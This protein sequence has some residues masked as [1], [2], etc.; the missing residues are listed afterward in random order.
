MGRQD[1]RAPTTSAL[2]HT[3][4][5]NG[6]SED[7]EMTLATGSYVQANDFSRMLDLCDTY[8][9]GIAYGRVLDLLPEYAASAVVQWFDNDGVGQNMT[10]MIEPSELVIIDQESA[11]W[12]TFYAQST[13]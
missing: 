13:N 9:S 2:L 4:I 1:G 6:S 11:F 12:Q 7:D 3:S 5:G 10:Y 8:H